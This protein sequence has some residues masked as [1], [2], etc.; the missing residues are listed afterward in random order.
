MITAVSEKPYVAYDSQ[1]RLIFFSMP[2]AF[3]K[4]FGDDS[5][6]AVAHL[7]TAVQTYSHL[8]PP[9][10]QPTTEPVEQSPE[11]AEVEPTLQQKAVYHFGLT[12]RPSEED[13]DIIKT[14]PDSSLQ[15]GTITSHSCVRAS[16]CADKQSTSSVLAP[17]NSFSVVRISDGARPCT[18]FHLFRYS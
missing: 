8:V 9:S 13:P 7:S 4:Y 16:V 14:T 2:N 5:E 12:H 18:S 3:K 17:Q 1:H 10:A 15:N 6:C 11:S